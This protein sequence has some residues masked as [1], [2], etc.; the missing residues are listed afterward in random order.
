MLLGVVVV[1]MALFL[2]FVGLP[3]GLALTIGVIVFALARSR[4]DDD[5]PE[6]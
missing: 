2:P 1:L 5:K 6:S 3:L 4:K